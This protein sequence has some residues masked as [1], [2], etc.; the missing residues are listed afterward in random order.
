MTASGDGGQALAAGSFVGGFVVEQ[1]IRESP[2][3]REY[4]AREPR[5][6][7]RVALRV[8]GG[9][10][11]AR[12]R[13]DVRRIAAVT[14]PSVMS[15]L[16]AG[17]YGDDEYVVVPDLHA[18]SVG[19]FARSHDLGSDQAARVVIDLAGALEA[20]AEA[21]MRLPL[22]PET[23][24][25]TPDGRGLLDP[26][27]S[28]E[29]HES[30]L[31][32]AD[33][34]SSVRELA[35]LLEE[36]VKAPPTQIDS[37]IAAVRSGE[38]MRPSQLALALSQS[39]RD[40]HAPRRRRGLLLAA[41]AAAVAVLAALA[42]LL[43]IRDDGNG[44]APAAPATAATARI[45]ARIPLGVR[46]GEAAT[47]IAFTRGVIW[48]PT[49][50]GRLLRVDPATN[51]VIGSPLTLGAGHEA[52]GIAV[53]AGSVWVADFAGSLFRIDPRTARVTGELKLG[54]RLNALRAAGDVLWVARAAPGGHH[55][56][57]GPGD[58]GEMIRVAARTM[59]PV[60]KPI[61]VMAT[62]FDLAIRG[63]VVW[64][65]GNH[66]DRGSVL[67]LDRSSG[68]RVSVNVGSQPQSL[69][70]RDGMLWVTDYV[71][72]VITP[73]GA[74]AMTFRRSLHVERV[75]LAVK[76]S[77]A[78]LWVIAGDAEGGKLRVTRFDRRS[79]RLAGRGVALGPQGESLTA[80]ETLAIRPDAVWV[81]MDKEL[82]RLAPTIPRPAL[83]SA[84]ATITPRPLESGPLPA[85]T[86]RAGT[87]A[88]PFSFTVPAFR[89]R[90]ARP[91]RDVF[92]LTETH[93][94]RHELDVVLPRQVWLNDKQL[95]PVGDP[96]RWLA[97]MRSHPRLHVTAVKHLDFDGRHAVQFTLMERRAV[98]HKDLCSLPCVPLFTDPFG[99]FAVFK[100]EV[101]RF[102]VVADRGRTIA[103][104]ESG[105]QR[106]DYAA[107]LRTFHFDR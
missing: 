33:T 45:L 77:V 54:K 31:T 96:E 12:L 13:T 15:V 2:G 69:A 100:D 60:G 37:A 82:I 5:L 95:Q 90:A 7:R 99:T 27:R 25:V 87:F 71:D 48:I 6:E 29:Q 70:F 98:P 47:G 64:V 18:V 3:F 74:D 73:I 55:F 32:T 79:G 20:L 61:A 107:L 81:L 72:G 38:Y 17:S 56:V 65:L 9:G 1:L 14:H 75:A 42:A 101:D 21:G 44:R 86:W 91:Q 97:Q 39:A 46:K 36:L 57:P 52:R 34:A 67:R 28:G 22:D 4:R 11:A 59:R 58:H 93:G 104:I 16:A 43:A 102:T 19:E 53:S 68:K 10:A 62:P 78:D 89:W 83:K 103:I 84:P 106:S 40:K 92:T 49:T 23:A 88:L 35:D 26:L 50:T 94:E 8:A 30:S 24:L 66:P 105:G 76:A 41:G 85:G 51:Q 80:G 63:T